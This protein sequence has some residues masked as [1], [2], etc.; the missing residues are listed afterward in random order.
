MLC[1]VASP[2]GDMTRTF[3]GLTIASTSGFTAGINVRNLFTDEPH[4]LS[5]SRSEPRTLHPSS[6]GRVREDTENVCGA[7]ASRSAFHGD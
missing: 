6:C 4:G 3:V 5:M 2:N 7:R 1:F